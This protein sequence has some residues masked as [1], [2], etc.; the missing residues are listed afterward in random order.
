MPG[1]L[2][3]TKLLAP[4]V[5]AGAVRRPRLDDLL[6]RGSTARL[7]L[8]SAPA[9]FLKDLSGRNWHCAVPK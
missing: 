3:E 2:V 1:P 6:V 8:V 7:T 4:R 9:R 5:R